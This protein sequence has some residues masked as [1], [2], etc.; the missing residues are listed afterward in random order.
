M[1]SPNHMT[2]PGDMN[3]RSA[4]TSTDF[5]VS[6]SIADSSGTTGLQAS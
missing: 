6:T 5:L 2:L 4:E 3:D 1:L